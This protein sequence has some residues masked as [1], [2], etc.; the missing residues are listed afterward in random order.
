MAMPPEDLSPDELWAR[1]QEVPRPSEVVDFPRK[2]PATGRPLSKIRI[3]VLTETEH[4]RARIEGRKRIMEKYGV[5]SNQLDDSV[6]REVVSD[7]CAR[8]ALKLACL[9]VKP[10]SAPDAKTPRYAYMFPND[11]RLDALTADELVALFNTY[12]LVQQRF[13]PFSQNLLSEEELNAW[14]RVL[15]E[16]A[17]A[18]FLAHKSLLQLAE[19]A[20]LLARRGYLLSLIVESLL[21]DSQ[22][23][24]AA[25]LKSLGIGTSWFTELRLASS[26]TGLTLSNKTPLVDEGETARTVDDLLDDYLYGG[27]PGEPITLEKAIEVSKRLRD[28]G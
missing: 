19:L 15:T 17:R 12:T 22:S 27:Q 20:T 16:G 14:I 11:E 18:N 10:I 1:M 7:A 26:D 28:D 25:Q 8:E 5:Q 24:S 4:T 2:D 9:S 6:M 13:G 21:K 3:Q 23:I